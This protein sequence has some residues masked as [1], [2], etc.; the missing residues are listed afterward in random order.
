M[1]KGKKDGL[2]V[3]S[4]VEKFVMDKVLAE[5]ANQFIYQNLVEKIKKKSI[6]VN[7]EIGLW[8][9]PISWK[10]QYPQSTLDYIP[11]KTLS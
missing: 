8:A 5:C 3:D 2:E 11:A 6:S 7:K 1:E 9:T 10:Q 4:K